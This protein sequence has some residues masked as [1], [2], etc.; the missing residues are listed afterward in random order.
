MFE[1]SKD[2]HDKTN[3]KSTKYLHINS[4]GKQNHNGNGYPLLRSRGR[5]D[6]HLLYVTQGECILIEDNNEIILKQGEIKLYKPYER[7][8]YR[9]SPPF[10]QSY[11]LHF[12]GIGVEEIM[13]RLNLWTKSI[14]N[15]GINEN[16][17]RLFDDIIR[18]TTLKKHCYQS[19]CE[20]KLLELLGYISRIASSEPGIN[21][22][23]KSGLIYSAIEQMREEPLKK[24]DTCKVAAM[25]GLSRG[26]F[27]HLF[28]EVTGLPPHK[29]QTKLRLDRSRY[30]LKNTQLNISEIAFMTGFSDSL[31]FSRIF[32]K[33]FG[34]PPTKYRESKDE[35]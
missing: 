5:V 25:L 35:I 34:C 20:G 13:K 23:D 17:I 7:Q 4:C 9:F 21:S 29:Y 6:Y 32:K 30:L 18:E 14:Y 26:R 33:T 31:Y 8:H 12:V 16:I 2:F 27:E 24:A 19:I 1:K 22:S 3:F 28:K 15:I 11:W 10:T